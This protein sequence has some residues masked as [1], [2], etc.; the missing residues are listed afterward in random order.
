MTSQFSFSDFDLVDY[1]HAHP[2]VTVDVGHVNPGQTLDDWRRTF[3]F[4]F[5]PAY[6]KQMVHCGL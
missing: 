2:E 4:A 6:Q 1:V 5:A 3:Q